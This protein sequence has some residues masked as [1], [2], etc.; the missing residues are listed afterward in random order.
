MRKTIIITLLLCLM[1]GSF[2]AQTVAWQKIEDA[3]KAEVGQK[4]YFFD[5]YTSWCGW[6]KRMDR[7]TFSDPTVSAILNKYYIPVK[8]NAE[9]NTQFDWNNQHF[10]GGIS[11][12]NRPAT[13]TFT[14]YVLGQKIGYP[15][16]AIFL[17]NQQLLQVIPGYVPA[18]DFVK[19]LW[20]FVS[21]DYNKYPFE[22]YQQIFD[23]EIAPAMQ[24]QLKQ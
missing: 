2:Q 22:K 3:A 21:G 4:M 20:Y 24:Q 7:D 14:R 1:G 10:T 16:F 9:S 23:K 13:H 8:F 5:F 15:S 17:P 19:I 11:V 12:N 18:S 6:C